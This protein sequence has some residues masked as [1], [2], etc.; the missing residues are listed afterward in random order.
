VAAANRGTAAQPPDEARF[1]RQQR[2]TLLACILGSGAAFLDGTIV[3]VALP[4]IRADLH[5]GLVTQ[6]WVIDAYLLT[7]SSLLL[8]GGSL[9]D[10][11]G[12]R[13]IFAAGVS[14]FGAASLLCAI[15]PNASLLIGAR[16]LQGAAGA[17]LVPSTL[18]LLMDTFTE[19]QRAAAIGSWTAWTGIATVVGPLA[20]G[21]LIQLGSWRW[22][23][24]V[25]LPLVLATL[26][27]V[28][29]APKGKP[30][31]SAHVDWIGG[32]LCALGLA[33]PIF[34][35]IEEPNYGWGDPLV[36]VPIAVG[37]ALLVAFILWE[38][39]CSAPMLPLELF[40]A[41]NFRVGNLS[42]FAF[43]GGLS[44]MTF[45]LVVFLQQVAGYTALA[46]GFS[47]LPMSILTFLLAKRFG[48]LADRFGPRLFMGCGPLI[49][50]AGLL[51]L[52][53]VNADAGYAA[54]VL[55]GVT[56]FALGLSMTVAPL[57]AAVLGAVESGHSGVASGVNNA[58]AR[59]AGLVAIAAVGAVIASQFSARLDEKLPPAS[60]PREAVAARHA[61][62]KPFVI[63]TTEFPPAERP[64][65]RAALV[66][67]S[68]DSYRVAIAIAAAL[69]ALSGLMS[70]FGIANP[71]RRV[72][73]ATCPGGALVGASS[74][75][76]QARLGADGS[77]VARDVIPGAA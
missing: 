19:H 3:N 72:A 12:R 8:V 49:A 31:A 24:V 10:V 63:D 57:T 45:V 47:L 55:P 36:W 22:V 15:A 35:L 51:L 40:R 41:R 34:G 46:A 52:L 59:V 29:H 32:A 68:E 56:V 27:L 25:N 44:V 6:E 42:T 13:K 77:V 71:R 26:Y 33:G 75:V 61:A 69:A 64:T 16:A 28:E 2:L 1:T 50:A 20:G 37:C 9:G 14:S 73:A 54:D 4:A 38:R 60:T 70:L 30:M 5:G 7:L 76:A 67:A 66:N 17:L 11:F 62:T 53:R 74:D 43:Y 18:A 58:I 65:A 23:F 48:A 21:L 39:R